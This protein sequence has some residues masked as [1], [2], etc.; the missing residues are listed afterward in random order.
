MAI[1]V[2][3]RRVLFPPTWRRLAPLC[4]RL[5]TPVLHQ[6]K[7]VK[8]RS[9]NAEPGS[10]EQE[11]LN[12]L[13]DAADA[14]MA[15]QEPKLLM[16]TPAAIRTHVM[17]LELSGVRM[18]KRHQWMINH[19][20]LDGLLGDGKL[21]EWVAALCP[22]PIV[23][24]RWDAEAP[25]FCAACLDEHTAKD[26]ID[27]PVAFAEIWFGTVFSDQWVRIFGIGEDN[28]AQLI[29]VCV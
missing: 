5:G 18:P 1:R 21:D 16:A 27:G 10:A 12:S 23:D 17:T 2:G 8:R 29:D 24:K 6:K 26:A 7:K 19:R 3:V 15:L 11:M 4:H 9:S 13:I 20:L 28:P 14:A 22:W 25:S